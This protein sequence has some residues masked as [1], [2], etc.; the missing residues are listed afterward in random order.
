[1]TRDAPARAV[2]DLVVGPLGSETALAEVAAGA[3]VVTYEWEGVPADA[4][5][6][7][8]DQLPV[9]PGARSLEVSQDRVAEKHTFRAGG[10]ATADYAPV[11]TRAE[12]GR[13]VAE[14]GVPGVL[15]TRRGGYDG[16]GQFVLRAAGDVERAWNDL[17]AAPL[18]LEAF[19]P[20]LRELSI[21]AVRALDG[22]IA[23]WPVVE[24]VHDAGILRMTR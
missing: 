13:A 20:F 3:D 15:K 1:P 17:G 6:F 14:L 23:C 4:A 18:I 19:V 5:R 8:N 16:K 12:L 9:R 22:S 7:L 24:N 11:S 2:G 21:V 10:M